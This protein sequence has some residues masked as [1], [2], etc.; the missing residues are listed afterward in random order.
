M[1]ILF[2]EPN[3]RLARLITD[4]LGDHGFLVEHRDTLGATISPR[5]DLILVDPSDESYEAL[6]LLRDQTEGFALLALVTRH[7]LEGPSRTR[8]RIHTLLKPFTIRDLAARCQALGRPA[9]T[10]RPALSEPLVL[11]ELHG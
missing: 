1:R 7:G 6:R 11:A 4:G 5:T 10:A 9:E 8:S 3:A 2:V